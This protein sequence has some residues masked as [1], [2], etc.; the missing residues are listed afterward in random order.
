MITEGLKKGDLDGLV[1]PLISIDEYQSKISDEKS[2][3]VGFYVFEE[4]AAH[5]LSNFAERSPNTVLDTDVSPAPTKDGYYMTFVE[6]NRD[7][8]FSE[9]L[10]DLLEEI[11][12]LT[13]V[14]DWQMIT[15]QLPPN[16]IL[17]VTQDNLA[18]YV[19]TKVESG[20]R[21]TEKSVM[22]FF[23]HSSLTNLTLTEQ[24]SLQ[25]QKAYQTVEFEFVSLGQELPQGPLNLSESAAA[26]CLQLEK[27]L[28]GPYN[29]YQV[30]SHTVI[31]H[32]IHNTYLTLGKA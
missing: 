23:R 4:D 31:Q 27:F 21:K 20:D 22:E 10:T 32:N 15:P 3:V 19:P 7:D 12:S 1:L 8:R 2:I 24:T 11:A 25:L 6:L 5:D 17:Q 14:S 16:K 29:V 28:L 30:G 18:K 26:E 9:T 13:N